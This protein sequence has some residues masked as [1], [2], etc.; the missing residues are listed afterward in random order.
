MQNWF[1]CKIRYTKIDEKTGKDKKVN[2]PYLVDAISFTEAEERIYREMEAYISG[3]FQVTNI[4]KAN[5]TDIFTSEDG[6]RW[7]KCKVTFMAID[8]SAGKEKK[9]ANQM[10]V[11]ASGVKDA[12]DKIDKGLEGMTVD[13]DIVAVAESPIMDFF[14]YFSEGAEVG[15]KGKVLAEIRAKTELKAKADRE[16]AAAI[17]EEDE[18]DYDDED[19]EELPDDE[20]EGDDFADE[21]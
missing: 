16:A 15:E 19:L 9:V 7:Y 18:E 4:R 2:E 20:A 21:E 10:L 14:P 11:L 17:L 3:E 1:E 8:E 12:C 13:Y 5:Y 6:E